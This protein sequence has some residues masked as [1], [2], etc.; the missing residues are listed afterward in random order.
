MAIEVFDKFKHVLVVEDDPFWRRMIGRNIERT[1][2]DCKAVFAESVDE[3]L[4][5]IEA[6][7]K[8]HLIIADQYL[9]GERTGY[10]LWRNCRERGIRTPFLLTSGLADFDTGQDTG[11]APRFIPK[12]FVNA[13]LRGAMF[14]L[15]HMDSR[16]ES[17]AHLVDEWLHED[18]QRFG[19]PFMFIA[20][21]LLVLAI[22]LASTSRLGGEIIAP[23][24]DSL[25]PS[26]IN[27]QN[28][29]P[30]SPRPA[31]LSAGLVLQERRPAPTWEEKIASH[32]RHDLEAKSF[33]ALVRSQAR[34]K[35]LQEGEL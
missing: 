1:A 19:L 24:P 23:P 14:E 29:Q 17:L 3:A 13:E 8:I 22:C 16:D 21:S 25:L 6:D 32:V 28:E 4:D 2:H 5:V 10:E 11:M 33:S 18:E 12:A 9:E 31:A 35:L 7:G 34:L 26:T 27:V 20:L 15:M 30:G